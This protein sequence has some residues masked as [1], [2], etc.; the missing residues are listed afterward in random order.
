MSIYYEYLVIWKRCDED[1]V[2]QF[3]WLMLVFFW[4]LVYKMFIF[5]M[6]EYKMQN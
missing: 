3:K 2:V 1:F 5:T 6:S 4:Q